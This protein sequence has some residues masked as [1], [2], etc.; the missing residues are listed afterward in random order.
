MTLIGPPLNPA[1]VKSRNDDDIIIFEIDLPAGN[2]LNLLREFR[3]KNPKPDPRG[4]H[5]R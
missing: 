3:K 2:S 5:E 4:G 1:R